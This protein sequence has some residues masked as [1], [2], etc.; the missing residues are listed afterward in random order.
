MVAVVVV[1]VAVAVVVDGG[2]TMVV[3]LRC[4]HVMRRSKIKSDECSIRKVMRLIRTEGGEPKD[5]D[6]ELAL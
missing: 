4:S 6:G 2:G 3:V 1:I 5:I